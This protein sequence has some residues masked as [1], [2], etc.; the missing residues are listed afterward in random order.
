MVQKPYLISSE[1]YRA[2]RYGAKHPLSIPRVSVAVDLIKAMGWF[3]QDRF[4]QGPIATPEQLHRFHDPDYVD[5]L[6]RAEQGVLTETE[7]DRWNI[8]RN[9]NPIYP[10]VYRRPATAAGSSILAAQ[11]VCGGGTVH[12]PAG[13]THHGRRD[14]ASGFCYLNDPVLGIL[15]LLDAGIAP[16]V[17]VDLDAHHGD[18]VEIA[19]QNDPRVTTLSIHEAGRWPRTGPLHHDL[20]P[21]VINIPVEPGF[22]DDEFYYI[23]ETAILPI[24]ANIEPEAIVIQ[25]GV[26]GLADDPM[27]K[28]A[29]SNSV[30]PTA[31]SALTKLAP[32]QIILGGGGYNPYAVARA[33]ALIWATLDRQD[34]ADQPLPPEAQDILRELQWRHSL[35]KNP[36][37]RWFDRLIDPPNNG[38]IRDSIR[39]TVRT[40]LNATG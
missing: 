26:D 33:W 32:R 3:P 37:S 40:V 9:G 17:Y 15:T 30:Y 24:V 1:I 31:V 19:F 2:S 16:V 8:G 27:S 34:V 10:E 13:G 7:K 39:D 20:G 28:L 38:P 18:G 14:Q 6:Q 12:S 35:A 5:A 23:L 4:I 25:C 36:P 29:L 22:Q 21:T 11:L